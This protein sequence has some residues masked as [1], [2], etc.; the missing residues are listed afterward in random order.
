MPR[1]RVQPF[2]S[3]GIEKSNERNDCGKSR[4]YDESKVDVI[5]TTMYNMYTNKQIPT[6]NALMKHLKSEES[7][8][9]CSTSTQWR[10]NSFKVK[11]PDNMS[12]YGMF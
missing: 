2:I 1:A 12:H 11:T 3:K 7:D 10:A 8:I 5:R 6:L 9:V 4:R